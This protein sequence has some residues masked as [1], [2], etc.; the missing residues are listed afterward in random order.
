VQD[1]VIPRTRIPATLE[2][3]AG[4]GRK[5]G[6][7][8]GNVF[9]AGDGNLH[10]LILF[11]PRDAD[12]TRRAHAAGKDILEY[13]V[14]IGGS[15]TGEHGVGMEKDHL[16]PLQFSASDL[17]VMARLR[18]AFNPESVL[19]PEKMIPLRGC[20]ETDAARHPSAGLG[21]GARA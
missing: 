7:K 6:F 5:Y 17:E 21:A 1:G 9:H 13:C 2:F 3:I 4:V 18:N 11:D 16:M 12:Q 15:I 20:R 19:N 8:I 10:P 14:S